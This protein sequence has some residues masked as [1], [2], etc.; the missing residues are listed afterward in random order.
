MA[1]INQLLSEANFTDETSQRNGWLSATAVKYLQ[2]DVALYSGD[3]ATAIS[4][5]NEVIAKSN[6][7]YFTSEGLNSLWTKENYAGR[8]FAF[9]TN[10]TYYSAIQYSAAEG[11]YFCVNPKL[12]F[13]NNDARRTSFY[14]P[15]TMNGSSRTLLV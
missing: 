10:T 6:D 8:I 11:D 4:K 1:A 14:Y 7:S 13:E 2:A 12:L 3:Y 15:F 5:G 9:N